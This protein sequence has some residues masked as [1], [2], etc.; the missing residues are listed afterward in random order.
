[1]LESKIDKAFEVVL[2]DEADC[3]INGWLSGQSSVIPAK[4][5]QNNSTDNDNIK[6]ATEVVP[7]EKSSGKRC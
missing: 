3:N 6:A 7:K 4:L 2:F 1:M 5:I